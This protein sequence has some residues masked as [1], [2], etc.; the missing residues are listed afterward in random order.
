M[1]IRDRVEGT[2][3]AQRESDKFAALLTVERLKGHEPQEN[4]CLLYTSCLAKLYNTS[5]SEEVGRYYARDFLGNDETIYTCLLYTSR[6][7]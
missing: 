3:R 7:V 5:W 2:A 4:P 1:C 6:C